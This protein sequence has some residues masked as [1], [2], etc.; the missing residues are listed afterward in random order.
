MLNKVLFGQQSFVPPQ[1]QCVHRV[2][3]KF[4]MIVFFQGIESHHLRFNSMQ[5]HFPFFTKKHN[6]IHIILPKVM[7][8]W[9][10]LL[11]PSMALHQTDGVRI[12]LQLLPQVHIDQDSK[13]VH[14]LFL[15]SF[16][17]LSFVYWLCDCLFN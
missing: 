1:P 2:E 17:F 16:H 6:L 9:Q 7:L 4:V 5:N 15:C 8:P 13:V 14:P 12:R 3:L 11:V 10:D